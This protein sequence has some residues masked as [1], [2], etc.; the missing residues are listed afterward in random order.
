MTSTRREFLRDTLVGGGS[1]LAAGLLPAIASG[2]DNLPRI[3]T[4]RGL[5]YDSTLCIGCKACM[6]ACKQAND[7]PPEHTLA[8][9]YW[10]TPLDLSGK[11]KTVI[12]MY[13]DGTA[14]VKDREVDGFAFIKASCMHCV[15][16]SCVSVCP[17]SAMRKDP[18][19]GIVTNN[20]DV[21]IGCRYCVAACPFKVPR[22]EYDTPFPR[23][24]K[25]ELCEHRMAKGH[26]AAC[27]AVCPTGATLY[28]QVEDLLRE[29]KRRLSL[30][31]G[32]ET[33]FPRGELG[34]ADHDVRAHTARY[35]PQIY[36][37]SEMGGTQMIF[38]AGVP[39]AKLGYRPL[40]TRSY[41]SV[42]ETLQHS[43]YEGMVMPIAALAG[44]SFLAYRSRV[45]HTL[46]DEEDQPEPAGEQP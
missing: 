20:P 30:S 4:A 33:R 31:P 5:L 43:L 6:A 3:P 37:E 7:L 40:P 36:G 23:I 2:R 27:A 32:E 26:Y 14:A 38:L 22:F 12:K 44:L 19:S 34:G 9:P 15:D 17:V 39:F 46:L 10:D 18:G 8:E 35:V 42:S 11:T 16:P 29:A 28:G 45:N 1:A 13:R 25:C 21:C 24:K 41:A